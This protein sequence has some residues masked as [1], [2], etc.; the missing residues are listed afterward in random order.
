MK[1][2]KFLDCSSFLMGE[3]QLLTIQ[4]AE[5]NGRYTINLP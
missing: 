1:K 2:I 4:V 5:A 3:E